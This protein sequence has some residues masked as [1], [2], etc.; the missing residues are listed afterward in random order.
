[1]L[2]HEDRTK[3]YPA[4]TAWAYW[5]ASLLVY[6]WNPDDSE[7]P[8][9]DDG[10]WL[11]PVAPPGSIPIAEHAEAVE[12]AWDDGVTAAEDYYCVSGMDRDLSR[13]A[14]SGAI[15]ALRAAGNLA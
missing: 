3:D 1:M 10:Y 2:D 14:Q 5:D 15:E 13:P 4:Q 7:S 6:W 8:V 11:G 9:A 12:R